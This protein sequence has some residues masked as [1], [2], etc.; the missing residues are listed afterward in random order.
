MRRRWSTFLVTGA[1]SLALAPAVLAAET[2]TTE[3]SGDNAVPP[4]EVDASGE[5]TVTISDDE[6]SVS[7]DISYRDLTGAPAAGHIHM[8]GADEN[9][10]VLIPFDSVTESGSTGTFAA[11]DYAGGEGLPDDWDGVLEEI[12]SGNAYVNI[13]TEEH[14]GGEIRGQLPGD[15]DAA[16][17]PPTDTESVAPTRAGGTAAA[18]LLV[19]VMLAGIAAL[20][21]FAVPRRR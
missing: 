9:G 17:A 20:S 10:P 14:P 15:D 8:G 7:W 4:I 6:Q 1:L 11:S 3:L 5:A 18:V 21:R 19:A 12:R 16:T 13:H 2:F